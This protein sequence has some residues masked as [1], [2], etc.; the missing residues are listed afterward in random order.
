[1]RKLPGLLAYAVITASRGFTQNLDLWRWYAKLATGADDRRDGSV[2][3]LDELHAPQ[4]IWAFHN[5]FISK[6]EGPAFNAT[7]NNVAIESLE[8]TVEEVA[9][10]TA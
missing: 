2:T 3:L 5:G 6:L 4:L 8:L 10:A 9:L 1:V 7:A